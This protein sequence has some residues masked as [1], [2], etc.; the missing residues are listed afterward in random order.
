MKQKKKRGKQ[1]A[2]KRR[3]RNKKNNE[4]L[5]PRWITKKNCK[6]LVGDQNC[7]SHK[8][9]RLREE[10]EGRLLELTIETTSYGIALSIQS[11]SRFLR[12]M[13]LTVMFLIG[14]VTQGREGLPV[15]E[16]TLCQKC[17]IG[18]FLRM[19]PVQGYWKCGDLYN[20]SNQGIRWLCNFYDMMYRDY[21]LLGATAEEP[22]GLDQLTE[23]LAYGYD[24][25][26]IS[27]P[28]RK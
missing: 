7:P 12:A 24:G 21:C 11:I 6:V 17:R 4:I 8:R 25:R 10:K 23:P 16:A 28:R 15:S 14:K 20:S 9:R 27:S 19:K 1:K 22:R 13:T 5:W 18:L 2:K 26:D 3:K